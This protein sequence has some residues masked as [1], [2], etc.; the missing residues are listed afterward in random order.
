ME[1]HGQLINVTAPTDSD[2]N[3]AMVSQHGTSHSDGAKIDALGKFYIGSAIVYTAVVFAGLIALFVHRQHH[4]VRIRSFKTICTT[5]L[6]LHIYLVL[7]LI[8]YPLNGLYKCWMEFWVMN[9]LLPLGIALFQA[10]NMRLFSYAMEQ[11]EISQGRLGIRQRCKFDI[12][13]PLKWARHRT[14]EQRTYDLIVVGVIVQLVVA[15]IIFGGSRKFHPS[16]GFFGQW[17]TDDQC[18]LGTEWVPSVMWQFLWAS[19]FGPYILLRTRDIRD[20]HYWALQTRMAIIAGLPGTPL[21]LAF[22]YTRNK[23]LI[24]INRYLK[25]AGW[26]LPGLITMQFVCI[27][28]PL[29]DIYKLKRLEQSFGENRSVPGTSTELRDFSDRKRNPYSMATLELQLER[30]PSQLMHWAYTKEFT[31]ENV[32]FLT[33]VKGFK[34]KW[35]VATKHT[36]DPD[37]KQAREL[38]EEAA[39][40][41]FTMVHPVTARRNIN[42]DS[43]TF[44]ELDNIFKGCHYDPDDGI[45]SDSKSSGHL[46]QNIV[47][48]WEEVETPER[49]H[50]AFSDRGNLLDHVNKLYPLPVTQIHTRSDSLTGGASETMVPAHFTNEVFDRAYNSVKDDVYLNTWVRP[51]VRETS[52]TVISAG[53]HKIQKVDVMA[54]LIRLINA[55]LPFTNPATPVLQDIIHLAVLCT[56]LWFAP[57]IEWRDLR[58]RVL[59]RGREE[60]ENVVEVENEGVGVVDGG[61]VEE[62]GNA[63]PEQWNQPNEPD[64][65]NQPDEPVF[66]PPG[67]DGVG[68]EGFGGQDEAGPANPHQPPRR[69]ANHN[70]EVGAKKAKSLA[71]RNQQRA[72]NEFLRE[73]GEAERAEWARDA[74][75]REEKVE[76]ERA[77]RVAREQKIKDKERK[78]REG[79]KMKEEEERRDELDAVRDAGE[80]VREG[81]EVDGF[82]K[83]EDLAKRVRRDNAWVERLIRREGILGVRFVDGKREVTMLTA[84]GFVVRVKED[85]MKI[86]YKRAAA[87]ATKGDGKIGWDDLGSAIQRVVTDRT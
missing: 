68:N 76:E 57:K 60:I 27:F 37:P 5:V 23:N 67:I 34:R 20:T 80:I 50:S 56:F 64:Q 71:R 33:A 72:Y 6:T 12:L 38:Y 55:F 65:P 39:M 75:E 44:R 25:P 83:C 43:P 46:T 28:F 70:K 13:K 17:V 69:T 85:M 81:L 35:K 52:T 59:G 22:I 24:Q 51:K 11:K 10:S 40:I 8:A 3:N 54:S 42:I 2:L 19:V 87:K 61:G 1:Y 29:L 16:Y 7:V 63:E 77:K 4:A 49:G 18:R 66:P 45:S 15:A 82:V 79:R 36:N 26:F 58:G 84:R 53:S 48:P 47:A 31:A 74:K 41:F 73:Q 62:E 30:K 86:A 14:I 32:L 9:I 21:W 78:E